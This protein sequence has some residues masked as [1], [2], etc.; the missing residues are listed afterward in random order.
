MELPHF[1]RYFRQPQELLTRDHTLNGGILFGLD[2]YIIEIQARAMD[3]RRTPLPWRGAVS[4]SGMAKGSVHEALDRIS[5]A[6]AKLAIPAP[7]VS[8]LVNL[9]P[10]DLPKEGTWLD[11]PLA[12]IILQASGLLPD[13]PEYQEGDFV[14]MGE[15][16]LHGEIRRVPG[17]LSI[18]YC[19]KT[20]QNL[21]VPSGN[22]KECA[23]ILAKSSQQ[24]CNVYPVGT[25]EEVIQFFQ[26]QRKLENALKHNPQF[27]PVIQKA[28]DFGMIRGQKRAKDAAYLAAAG[29]HN[30]LLFGPPGEG[31]SL[32]A[33]ALPG[34]MP[35]LADEEKVELTRIYSAFGALERDGMA[36]TRRPVRS[37]HHTASK[38]ALVGG[39]SKIPRPGEI[40]LAHLGVLF[41]DEIAEFSAATLEALRQPMEAGEIVISR[42]GASITYPCRFTLVA[43]MNPCPCGYHGTEQCRCKEADIRKYQKKLS[44]PILDRIDLQVELQRLSTEERFAPPE[45]DVSPR[46]RSN[47]EAARE[48]QRTRFAGTGIPFNAAIPGGRVLDYCDLS[49]AGMAKYKETVQ[50]NTLSTRSMDRL[51]KVARTIADL[52]GAKQVE[53]LHV[54]KASSFVIGGALREAF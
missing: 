8:I 35:R 2:G 14:I 25:L 39:G 47:I 26:G 3:V 44:G 9:A 21:I 36:V 16:G 7:Q 43:A 13:L 10:P 40:T 52:A 33:G 46:L 38:Q 34:I 4:I 5:G 37:I 27:E 6:F 17:A 31:K 45:A 11:L 28:I 41:L 19:A 49:A 54:T 42:V 30:L 1:K 32:L 23:L 29:G 53:P 22:E 50:N 20:G 48:R 18:A 24:G 12:I 51:A 15:V